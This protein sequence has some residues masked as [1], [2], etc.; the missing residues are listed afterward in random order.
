MDGSSRFSS[1]GHS[2]IRTFSSC[3]L[4][5]CTV[6][7]RTVIADPCDTA[8][9]R[10]TNYFLA[11]PSP[12]TANLSTEEKQAQI[13]SLPGVLELCHNWGTETDD[14]FPG[15]T[16]GN[17]EG[18]RGFGHIAVSVDDVQKS[19]ERFTEMG[20]EFKKR[21]EEGKMKHIAL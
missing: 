5:V 8:S 16:N 1:D 13:T 18:K 10:Q 14:S 15:Y 3:I 6:T 20:V 12:E 21:P 11:F 2:L 4:R 17:E 9:T 19:C 7:Y